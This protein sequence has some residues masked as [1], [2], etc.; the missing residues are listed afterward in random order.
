M[1]S[2]GQ[3]CPRAALATGS[4]AGSQEPSSARPFVDNSSVPQ[5]VQHKHTTH[6]SDISTLTIEKPHL[7]NKREASVPK[8]LEKTGAHKAPFHLPSST[9]QPRCDKQERWWQR[10]ASLGAA[11]AKVPKGHDAK[12][13]EYNPRGYKGTVL[14]IGSGK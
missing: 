11:P 9:A 5:K 13:A 2:R 8:A 12:V 6:T 1:S 7:K 3:R 4:L 14:S 10:P